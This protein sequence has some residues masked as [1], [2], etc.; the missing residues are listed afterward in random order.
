MGLTDGIVVD[1]LFCSYVPLSEDSRDDIQ[2]I[3][4][5]IGKDFFSMVWRNIPFHLR[6]G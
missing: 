6:I 3:C 2:N 1:D 4:Q 5:L